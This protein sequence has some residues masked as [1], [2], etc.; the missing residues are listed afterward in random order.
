MPCL[1]F[2]AEVISE[3]VIL[4]WYKDGHSAKGKSVFLEQM[5]KF[6][7]W[8]QNAEEGGFLFLITWERQFTLCVCCLIFLPH[9]F[10]SPAVMSIFLLLFFHS[11]A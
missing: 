6:V 9:L 1:V 2:T 11:V 5:K 7:E 3:D 4:R 10:S 8:L